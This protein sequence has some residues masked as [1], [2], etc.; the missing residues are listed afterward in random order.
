MSADAAL[1]KL[2]ESTAEA[3]SGLLEMF[4]PGK[5]QVAGVS[6]ISGEANPL[7]GLPV[8]AVATSVSYV[9]GVTGGNVFIL[10]FDGA[11]ALAAAMMEEARAVATKLGVTFRVDIERRIDGAARVGEHRTSMLQDVEAGRPLEVD[12]LVGAVVEIG[13]LCDLELPRLE[14]VAACV[15][16][17]DRTLK[18]G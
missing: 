7:D 2:G 4:A 6:V 18:E 10:T 8:P 14:T 3:A 11:R 17:L 16:L 13:H 9:D 5:V 15:K 12:A 1:M